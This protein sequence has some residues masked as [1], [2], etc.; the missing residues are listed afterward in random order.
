MNI[1]EIV[2]PLLEET[3]GKIVDV[4][5]GAEATI[6]MGDGT[7]TVIDLKK[8]PTALVKSPDG[9]VMMSKAGITAG[10]VQT[11]KPDPTSMMKPGEPVFITDKTMEARDD[12]TNAM[13]QAVTRRILTRHPEWI[14]RYGIEFLMQVIDDVTEGEDDWD[15]IGSSDVSAYVRMVHQQL[16]DRGGD[17]DEMRDREPFLERRTRWG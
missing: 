16:Q 6:D 17:R 15:E 7:K 13:A 10:G 14:S 9:K 3:T 8:N 2:K 12:D 5:P 4:K 1:F 11:E